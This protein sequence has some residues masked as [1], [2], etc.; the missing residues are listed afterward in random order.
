MQPTTTPP[1]TTYWRPLRL[2]ALFSVFSLLAITTGSLAYLLFLLFLLFL[3][4]VAARPRT[5]P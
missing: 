3:L 2:A 5:G 1:R 4:P